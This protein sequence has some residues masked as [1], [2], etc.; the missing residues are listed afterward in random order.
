MDETFRPLKGVRVVDFSHVVAGPFATLQLAMLGADVL[1]IENPNGGDVIRRSER[2]A[3]GYTALNAGKRSIALAI[4]TEEGR[5]EALAH[6]READV[7]VDNL[8]PGVLEKHGLGFDAVK[9]VNPRIVYCTISGYGRHS[10]WGKRAAYDHVVQAATGMMLMAGQ[11]D[12]PPIKAGFPVIDCA[13]GIIAAMSILAG[14]RERDRTG[15]GMQLDVSMAASAM[16]LMYPFACNALTDGMTPKRVGNQGYSGSPVA[17]IFETIDGWIAIGANNQ[18]Q[19][20]TLLEALGLEHIASDRE[21]FPAPLD[22]DKPAAFVRSANPDLLKQKLKAYLRSQNAA[23]LEVVLN[24]AKVPASRVRN[25][26]EFAQE[27]KAMGGLPLRVLEQGDTRVT[28]PGLGF[29]VVW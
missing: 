22:A 7:F 23:Q 13:A 24:K 25:I 3:Q 10:E 29:G 15:R 20:L 5:R 2:G 9:Q 16:Q 6:A 1:K 19:V 17:D 28:S 26:A 27:A 4:D 21:I 12:D 14:L 11:E 8:R 18:K